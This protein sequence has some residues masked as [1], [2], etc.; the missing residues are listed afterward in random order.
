MTEV[1]NRLS[2]CCFVAGLSCRA[3]DILQSKRSCTILENVTQLRSQLARHL[4]Y[5]S[6]DAGMTG[7]R[8]TTAG[9][10]FTDVTPCQTPNISAVLYC[11]A[12]ETEDPKCGG[13]PEQGKDNGHPCAGAISGPLTFLFQQKGLAHCPCLEYRPSTHPLLSA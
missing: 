4:H 1:S 6:K 10:T 11:C 7:A 13:G 8:G 9:L 2:N 3:R 12:G 5:R